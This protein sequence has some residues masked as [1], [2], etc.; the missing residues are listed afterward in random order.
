MLQR[1]GRAGRHRDGKI[2]LLMSSGLEEVRYKK[3]IVQHQ[4]IQKAISNQD[5]CFSLYR[6]QQSIITSLPVCIEREFNLSKN[7]IYL[8]K[9]GAVL[10][11]APG[12]KNMKTYF[13]PGEAQPLPSTA[14]VEQA[15]TLSLGKYLE[16]Q[17]SLGA[18]FLVPHSCT[19]VRL[20][21]LFSDFESLENLPEPLSISYA[22][23]KPPTSTFMPCEKPRIYTERHRLDKL[24]DRMLQAIAEM[25]VYTDPNH[26]APNKFKY[27]SIFE[28]I[29]GN[30]G[31]KDGT[32]GAVDSNSLNRTKDLILKQE[33]IPD[34]FFDEPFTPEIRIINRLSQLTDNN[35]TSSKSTLVK[36]PQSVQRSQRVAFGKVENPNMKAFNLEPKK[37]EN[38]GSLQLNSSQ[39]QV[40]L[41]KRRQLSTIIASSSTS[42]D[43]EIASPKVSKQRCLPGRS[44]YLDYEAGCVNETEDDDND[45]DSSHASLNAFIDDRSE[46][47]VEGSGNPVS[48]SQEETVGPP[49]FDDMMAFYRRTALQSQVDPRFKTAPRQ[50]AK[51]IKLKLQP[52][53]DLSLS[54][55]E[56]DGMVTDLPLDDIDWSS[57]LD[58]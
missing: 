37:L 41:P 28:E 58:L 5:T 13:H 8:G 22:A 42:L 51:K 6:P 52:V 31:M 4:C 46:L 24:E 1:M 50:F 16:W 57:D 10:T 48:G 44:K 32:I 20:F 29:L 3:T 36:A 9:N 45:E 21:R 33:D 56:C 19:T 43:S 15:Y 49:S 25:S 30:Y 14:L 12:P 47:T 55:P 53:T 27:L 26:A 39:I 7:Q 18:T 40:L 23:S 2:I 17:K 34:N 35:P 54:E 38:S 11:T